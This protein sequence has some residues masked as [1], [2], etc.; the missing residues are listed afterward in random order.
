MLSGISR[1]LVSDRRLVVCSLLASTALAAPAYAQAV[2]GSTT[3][4]TSQVA[5]ETGGGDVIVTAQK[6]VQR[7]VDVPISITV[8]TARDIAVKN[9]GDL[10]QLAQKMPNVNGGGSFFAGFTIR[11]I[12]SASAGSGF[13]PDVGVNV[14]EVFMGRDRAF[15]TVLADVSSVELL[16]GPQGTLYG[17]NTIAGVINITTQRPTDQFVAKG[18][19]EY[20]S[21]N[22]VQARATIAGPIIEDK[23]LVSLTGSYQ[24]RDGYINDPLLH[25]RL[26]S[27]NDGGARIMVV[28]HPITDLTVELRADGYREQDTA[29]QNETQSTIRGN[30]LPFPPFNTVGPQ[31]PRDRIVNVNTPPVV[32]RTLYGT[33]A[34]VEYVKDDYAF[35]SITAYRRIESDFDLDQDGG[36]LDGFDTGQLENV[37]RFSQ[38]V[39][40]TSPAGNRF[41][42]IAGL[43]Y[44]NETDHDTFHIHVGSGFPTALFGAPFPA[45]LPSTF[46]ERSDTDALIHSSSIAGF[47]SVKYDVTSKLKFTGGIRYTSETKHLDYTQE[48]TQLSPII[49]PLHVIFSFAEP[50]PHTTSNYSGSAPSGEANLSYAFTPDE[51]GYVRYSRGFKSGGF[52]SDVIS[53]PFNVAVNGLSFKPEFLNDYEV[54]FKAVMFDHR[55]TANLAAFYYDFSNKQEQINTGV[56][57]V[58]SN[59]ASATSRGAEVELNWTPLPGLDLFANGGYL[60]AYYNKF[61]NGGGLGINYNGRRL[62]GASKYS[63]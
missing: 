38:E 41:S 55:L 63:A 44:D 12:S 13:P 37:D 20:G 18:D 58:V 54:G 21:L 46:S 32:E 33:S 60:D 34:K 22:F 36:P 2:D 45:V 25:Q 59:A 3:P 19:F 42:W 57:F 14:D 53:P 8:N 56:S 52:Q 17:K 23:L 30:I 40:I 10:T 49:A 48:P 1:R 11:G 5:K 50:I 62:A 28:L 39:R 61:P 24:R 7:N 51:V 47:V 16:R 31:N 15:D 35:T 6:R 29:G 43:Y 26:G 27:L 4:P 9:I